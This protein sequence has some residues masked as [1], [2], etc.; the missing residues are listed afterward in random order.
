L[1]V[2]VPCRVAGPEPGRCLRNDTSRVSPRVFPDGPRR[3]FDNGLVSSV[4]TIRV[5]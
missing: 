1:L 4:K 2:R 3:W 5:G